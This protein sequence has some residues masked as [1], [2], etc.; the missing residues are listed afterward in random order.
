MATIYRWRKKAKTGSHYFNLNGQK[1]RITPGQEVVAPE[2]ALGSA[3][4]Q[5]DRLEEIQSET[6]ENNSKRST[7][8]KVAK[9]EEQ[10]VVKEVHLSAESIGDNQYNVFNP[11]NPEKPLNDRPLTWEETEQVLNGQGKLEEIQA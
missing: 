5:Y 6:E 9:K 3:V 4:S 1:V 2:K 11:D 7:K 8:K 10:E